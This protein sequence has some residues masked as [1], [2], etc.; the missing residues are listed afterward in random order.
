MPVGTGSHL[1]RRRRYSTRW[2]RRIGVIRLAKSAWAAGG[3]IVTVL[4]R[5]GA[6]ILAVSCTPWAMVLCDLSRKPLTSR[7]INGSA[8]GMR[9]RQLSPSSGV[10]PGLIVA[11]T[12]KGN[13]VWRGCQ[14]FPVFQGLQLLAGEVPSAP[15]GRPYWSHGVDQAECRAANFSPSVGATFTTVPS[16]GIPP[17]NEFSFR[18]D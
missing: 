6:G 11:G 5:P 3:W 7:P 1:C 8:A 10:P 14:V 17:R 16:P 9:G 4:S 18:N 12:P 13:R 15:A 2:L